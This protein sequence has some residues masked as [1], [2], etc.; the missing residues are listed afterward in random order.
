MSIRPSTI[1]R[2]RCRTFAMSITT[3]PVT[4]PNCAAWRIRCAT[5]ALQ[6]SFLLG[7]QA[8]LGQEPPIHRRSTTAVRRPDPAIC[9]ANTLPP[10]PL[11]RIKI[12]TCS[13]FDIGPSVSC[14]HSQEALMD[15]ARGRRSTEFL[16]PDLISASHAPAIQQVCDEIWGIDDGHCSNRQVPQHL[17]TVKTHVADI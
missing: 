7:R 14:F 1:S 5:L 6:I 8:M 16:H 10:A 3:G 12:S 13:D 9:Q 4:M 15:P 2:L 11:P 17:N